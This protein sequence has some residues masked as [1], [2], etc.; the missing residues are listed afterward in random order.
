MKFGRMEEAGRL[1]SNRNY[2]AAVWDLHRFQSCQAYQLNKNY[3]RYHE[4]CGAMP[5]ALRYTTSPKC[6]R[7]ARTCGTTPASSRTYATGSPPR[8]MPPSC[9]C[10]KAKKNCKNGCATPPLSS[11]PCC[12]CW[13]MAGPPPAAPAPAGTGRA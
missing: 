3:A 8:N 7:T 2:Q 12:W 13:L 11:S 9:A 4:N 5:P 10:W 1:C 6:S